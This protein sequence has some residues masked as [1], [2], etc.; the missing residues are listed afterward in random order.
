MLELTL[1]HNQDVTSGFLYTDHFNLLQAQ[2]FK[3]IRSVSIV[4]DL[5]AM[6]ATTLNLITFISYQF[7][8]FLELI[9]MFVPNK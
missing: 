9:R 1:Y 4:M 6:F 8:S 3:D 5:N 2:Y 7:S